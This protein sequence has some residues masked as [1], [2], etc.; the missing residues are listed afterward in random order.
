ME[1]SSSAP[2]S[3]IKPRIIIHGGAGNITRTNLTTTAYSA[4]RKALLSILSNAS[5]LLN[6]PGSTALDVATY[7]VSL[8]ENEPLFNAGK[9]A[10]FTRAGTTE[11]EASVMVTNGYRK[12]GV[13][14]MLLQHVKNPIKLAREMLIR[15]ESLDGGGAQGHC[16]LA[17]HSA[18]RLAEEW[19]LE[20]VTPDYFY[21]QRRWDEHMKGLALEKQR[22]TSNPTP[23]AQFNDPFP[24]MPAVETK[25]L[26]RENVDGDAH[27]NGKDYLPQGTVGC[28]VLD[29]FGTICVATSTG[30]LT[31][32][33]PGRIGDT[34]TLGA[35]YWAEEW[36]EEI[37]KPH[38]LR[39][40]ML[41]Q[42]STSEHTLDKLS[43]G[44][45]PSLISDC[46]PSSPRSTSPQIPTQSQHSN[47][48]D[49]PPPLLRHAVGMSGTGN[50]DSFLRMA[51]VR[52][53]AAVS[54]FSSPSLSL[55]IA[56]SLMAG[57]GGELQKSAGERWG[58]T[59]EGEGG[60][61]G[62][63]LVE[64]EGKVVWD[65][66]CGGMFKAWIDENG[67]GRCTV[68]KEEK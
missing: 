29:S 38:S 28:V 9:G 5:D 47:E 13:G 40:Q 18:E 43:R 36:F 65:F 42:R 50:G 16:Q 56:V 27:W 1:T 25:K 15:G 58:V 14:C 51:A 60:I 68:F 35:G 53:A 7:A 21:T 32:K 23:I 10:V 66:N 33:L 57:P 54:R 31:N 24:Y 55:D 63:E 52:T 3:R 26:G 41:Y 37:L 46:L 64:N 12:R 6:K 22:K 39:P 20:M 44:D 62:I 2:L 34:P 17:G 59:G 30:G 61:I 19:G 48:K 8:L 45:F 67:V 49:T 4:Y 11:L